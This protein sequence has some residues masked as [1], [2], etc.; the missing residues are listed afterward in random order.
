MDRDNFTAVQ[1]SRRCNKSSGT[2]YLQWF[3]GNSSHLTRKNPCKSW[4][5]GGGGLHRW[6]GKGG[7]GAR[8]G[9]SA[10]GISEL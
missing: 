4:E 2:A 7:G 1:L 10:V 5:R 6:K 9:G 3:R 8:G